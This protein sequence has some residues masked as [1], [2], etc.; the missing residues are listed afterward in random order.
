ER[1]IRNAEYHD[2]VGSSRDKFRNLVNSHN[3]LFSIWLETDQV[4]EQELL[5]NILMNFVPAFGKDQVGL[6]PTLKVISDSKESQRSRTPPPSYE[7]VS[8]MLDCREVSATHRGRSMS[9][10][11]RS[12]NSRSHSNVNQGIGGAST[13]ET[14]RQNPEPRAPTSTENNP[15]N[16]GANNEINATGNSDNMTHKTKA[17]DNYQKS[18]DLALNTANNQE[19]K[20]KLKIMKET[21][22]DEKILRDWESWMQEKTAILV[23]RDVHSTN[24]NLHKEINTLSLNKDES[25]AKNTNLDGIDDDDS[26]NNFIEHGEENQLTTHRSW[27]LKSGTNVGD[28][29]A[30]YVKTIPEAHKCLNFKK[31]VKLVE[32]DIP[33]VV[34]YFFDEVEK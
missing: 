33:D 22:D 20:D 3:S 17:S 27:V 34:E 12:N 10:S 29:L 8:S 5:R 16:D 15:D 30:K 25:L 9:P 6:H 28:E 19:I 18:L 26:Y 1:K 21:V 14:N 7:E 11:G 23:R 24:L 13:A 2:I 32:S 31:E 4:E